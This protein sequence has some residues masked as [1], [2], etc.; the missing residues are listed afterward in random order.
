VSVFKSFTY[1]GRRP[2]P[3]LLVTAAVHGNER[4]GTAALLRLQAQLDARQLEVVAGELTLVPVA[5]A[6]AYEK[7]TRIGQRNLNRRLSPTAV[8]QVFEDH[9]ANWL[10]SLLQRHDVLVDL[11]SFSAPGDAFVLIGPRDN[12]GELEPRSHS[13]QEEALARVLGVDLGVEGWLSTYAQGALRRSKA[14]NAEQRMLACS[15]GVG[16]TEYMRSVGGYAVTLECGQHDDPNAV[17]VAYRAVRAAMAHLRMTDEATPA[18]RAMRCLQLHEVVD[19]HSPGD[20]F[21][22]NWASFDPLCKGQLI[23]QRAEGGGIVA[24]EDCWIVFPDRQAV[25]GTDWFYLA[26]HSSRLALSAS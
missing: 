13:A 3:R 15:A 21:A 17:E 23:A 22:Q 2:G 16:T 18:T 6:L 9:A 19:R 5:N 20:H 1:A 11:H 25:V 26:R 8:P 7:N 14:A 24:S 10:C 12:C 4:C